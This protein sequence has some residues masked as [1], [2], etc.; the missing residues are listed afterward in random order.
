MQCVVGRKDTD[1][2]EGNTYC[3]LRYTQQDDD[4]AEI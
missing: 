3:Q 2:G 1:H 4:N